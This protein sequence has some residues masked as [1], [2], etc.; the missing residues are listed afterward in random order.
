PEAPVP[1]TAAHQQGSL[2]AVLRQPAVIALLL[3]C[4]ASQLS[5][6]PYYNFFTLLLERHG[7]ARTYV[8]ALWAVA[9]VA[10]IVLFIYAAPII[11]RFGARRVLIAALL[12]TV[13]RWWLTPLC[14][15]SLALLVLLQIGHALS[16]G[17]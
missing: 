5:F 6:A 2:L 13:L 4:F 3:V 10:E 7:H 17:A 8:G 11:R 1:P 16:F 9:V 15:D 12:A 14:A